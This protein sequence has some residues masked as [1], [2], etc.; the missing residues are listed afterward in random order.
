MDQN[1]APIGAPIGGTKGAPLVL[2][3]RNL[4]LA[5]EDAD[6]VAVGINLVVHEGEI[7]CLVGKS[8]MG[9]TTILHALAGLTMP[10]EGRVLLHG[11]DVTGQPGF[12][13]YMLQKDLLLPS[14]TVIDNAC[15]PLTLSGMPKSQARK[16]ALPLIERFGLQDAADKWPGQ[17]SGGM[18]QRAAFLRT[19]LMGNDVVMLDE[20]FS[21][22]DAITRVDL[23]SWFAEEARSLGL[24]TLMITHDADEACTLADRVYVLGRPD[25]RDGEEPET[26]GRVAAGG[27]TIANKHGAAGERAPATIVGEV[28]LARPHASP[29]VDFAL[30]P[31][32]LE[33]KS[34]LLALL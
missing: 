4:T 6:P 22:L 25:F 17:L 30:T 7:V 16:K 26:S 20:P 23:R 3:A 1:G 2:E 10:R 34:R 32:F 15:L 9:K 21:A 28:V 14:L 29:D 33:A 27:Q 8:G 13:S 11:R 5:W 19:Y 31:E 12:V 18:R 24:S